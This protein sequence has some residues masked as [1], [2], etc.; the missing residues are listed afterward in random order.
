MDFCATDYDLYADLAADVGVRVLP[1]PA[2]HTE[3]D[4]GCSIGDGAADCSIGALDAF[5]VTSS[6]PAKH[7]KVRPRALTG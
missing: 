1:L 2:S 5:V 4:A 7:N 3:A 6:S